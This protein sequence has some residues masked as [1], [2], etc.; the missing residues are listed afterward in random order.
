M[1]IGN[2]KSEN[3]S[4]VVAGRKKF[5]LFVSSLSSSSDLKFN[6]LFLRK[7]ETEMVVVFTTFRYLY[8]SSFI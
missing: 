6:A 1:A 3:C 4:F 2:S 5:V 8:E 7:M